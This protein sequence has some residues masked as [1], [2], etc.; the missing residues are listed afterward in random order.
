MALA[1]AVKHIETREVES[2]YD[3]DIS[4]LEDIAAHLQI[5]GR[6][7]QIAVADAFKKLKAPELIEGIG[8]QMND[9]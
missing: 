7:S 4:V 3:N 5:A 1:L 8:L 9:G 2:D 6:N